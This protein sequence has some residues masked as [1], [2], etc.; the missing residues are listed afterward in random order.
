MWAVAE[1]EGARLPVYLVRGEDE[2][3]VAAESAR[4]VDRLV[5]GADRTSVIDTFDAA[6]VEAPALVSACQTPPF[7]GDRRII[8]L[9]RVGQLPEPAGRALRTYLDAPLGTTS[10]VL[11]SGGGPTPPS[12]VAAARRVKGLIEVKAP[13]GRER[14]QWWR[15]RLGRAPVRLD[16]GA[17][18][19]L[20]D[21]VGEDVA[22]LDGLLQTLADVYGATR[23]LTR[24]EIEPFLGEAGGVPPW[25]LLDALDAGSVSVA[26][27]ELHRLLVAGGRHPLQL[28][29]ILERPFVLALRAHGDDRTDAALASEWTTSPY[30][31]Q[32]ARRRADRLGWEGLRRAIE[33]L[34]QADVDLR[35]A[36]GAP[37]DVVLEVLV[38]R[39]AE[40][41]SSGG[42]AAPRGRASGSKSRSGARPRPD[43]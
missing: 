41:R 21:H 1:G 9:R 31:V 8:V 12:L 29:A 25:A 10:V 24:A 22:R 14:E 16:A 3:L 40:L 5:E 28:M 39:L 38:L 43:G 13:A 33:L 42:V 30:V 26:L 7:F 27:R 4:L 36:T 19:L 6:D 35:G 32:A 15:E 11:V 23:Q 34:A 18:R 17:R 2:A 20:D 37:P